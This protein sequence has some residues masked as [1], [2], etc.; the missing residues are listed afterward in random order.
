M[1][2]VPIEPNDIVISSRIRLA[3]NIADFPFISTC[4]D[5]QRSEIEASILKG[6]AN[7]QVLS[8]LTVL[9]SFELNALERQFLM[10]LQLLS[11]PLQETTERATGSSETQDVV[12][13]EAN[14]SAIASELPWDE[15]AHDG[16]M[17]IW[18]NGLRWNLLR[19]LGRA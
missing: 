5:D 15:L 10:D 1:N 14:V 16:Y 19:R 2:E 13:A 11:P 7:D 17:P 6:I 9:N 3:R 8:D 12:P 4:S 18:D